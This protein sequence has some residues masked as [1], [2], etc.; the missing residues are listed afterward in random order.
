MGGVR[1]RVP[2][3]RVPLVAL[4]SVVVLFGVASPAASADS[5]PASAGPD[6]LRQPPAT[7]PQ[8]TNSGPWQAPPILISGAVAYRQ[9]EF[10]YQDWLYDDKGAKGSAD[11]NY[12]PAN[13]NSEKGTG[14]Y[15]YPSGSGY[16]NNTADLVEVRIRRSLN[17]TLFRVT[18]NTLENP[19][20]VG[21]TIALGTATSSTKQYPYG[22]N[23]SG[24]ADLFV[25]VH[26]ST[27]V[28]SGGPS[29]ASASVSVDTTR[30]QFT[31]TVPDS[32]WQPPSQFTVAV[33]AGLWDQANDRY[34][35]PAANRTT[36]QPGGAGGLTNP[37]A[38]FNVAFR[39]S[40]PFATNS[41][42]TN[43]WRESQ[44]A[45]QLANHT[46]APF[47]ITVDRTK[48]DAGATDE[49][50]VPTSGAMDRIFSSHFTTGIGVDRTVSCDGPNG[51]GIRDCTGQYKGQLQPYYVY[52]PSGSPASYGLVLLLHAHDANYNQYYDKKMVT[53]LAGR[54]GRQ[55]I[56]L[57]PEGRASSGSYQGILLADVFEAWA[58]LASQYPLDPNFTVISG[59]SMGSGGAYRVAQAYPDLFAAGF[60]P[61]GANQ[62]DNRL[63]ALRNVPWLAWNCTGDAYVS[64]DER[65]QDIQNFR[66]LGYRFESWVFTN[67]P[68]LPF[69]GTHLALAINDEWSPAVDWLGARTVDPDPFH[70]T[71]VV[72]PLDAWSQY[73]LVADHAYWIK[74]ATVRTV[75][76]D[77]GYVNTNNNG[78]IEALSYAFGKVDSTASG[79]TASKGQLT[80]GGSGTLNYRKYAQSWSAAGSAAP[81]DRLDLELTNVS[82]VVIDVDRA[83]LSC[84]P[85]LH[86]ATDGDATISL[87]GSSCSR[88]VTVGSP[89]DT[90]I[91]SGPA[92]KSR[93]ASRSATFSFS[94]SASGATFECRVDLGPWTPCSS[95]YTVSGLTNGAHTF[96]VRAV[97]D[98]DVA[99][100]TPA[101]RS[102]FVADWS[103]SSGASFTLAGDG[104]LAY[105]GEGAA[106]TFAGAA[107]PEGVWPL[108]DGGYV[109]ADRNGQR[110]RKVAADGSVRTVAGTGAKCGDP[111]YCGNGGTATSAKL[112][113]PEGVAVDS[114]GRV[115][116]ADLGD[117][118]VRRVEADGTIRSVAGNNNA[119]TCSTSGSP[120]V[121]ANGQPGV[122]TSPHAVL[123]MPDG[124]LVIADTGNGSSG[125]VCVVTP[126]GSTI[127]KFVTTDLSGQ[128]PT[129]LARLPDG[130]VLVVLWGGNKVCQVPASGG[131]CVDR[132]TGLN[133]PVSAWA[134]SSDLYIAESGTNR[135][136]RYDPSTFAYKDVAFGNGD[137][138][139]TWNWTEGAG[140]TAQAVTPRFVAVDGG[141]NLVVSSW[142]TSQAS[143]AVPSGSRLVIKVK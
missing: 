79:I 2:W 39:T 19:D 34:L 55:S 122:L 95:P 56:V 90:T 98:S 140:A 9:G 83:R 25:T 101:Q 5:L 29:G 8:L 123:P 41:D 24:P 37:P 45:Q 26:G 11:S 31:V 28:V 117:H 63:A 57:V 82:R 87:R 139:D 124:S 91:S 16:Y 70:V 59:Y 6:L 1:M 113:T 108:A 58:D 67:C 7:A 132:I 27:A 97:N 111:Q 13:A 4:L 17:G 38:F 47:T 110:V 84:N 78:R 33:G 121:P 119:G 35:I 23:V 40:E 21:F 62:Q 53:Q 143:R 133:R 54:G 135:V 71:Y 74:R 96:A 48:L 46:M 73:S 52:V 131:S 107:A 94:S 61:T 76:S 104:I 22:A 88:D 106:G 118:Q 112:N 114:A 136:K 115:L 109:F 51:Y 130:S 42:G 15:T 32:T 126:D 18:F 50:K 105:G 20:L 68:G 103:A 36:T 99:D 60:T 125:Q 93:V 137:P 12:Q 69:V 75:G 102:F 85:R 81:S 134:T 14:T 129:G 142:D 49:S 116:I 43:A 66:D 80:G 30:K 120:A 72:N 138:A 127:K 64:D 44:Q 10:I 128:R 77:N 92:D 86:V 89:P 3:V 141:G 100:A 65:D